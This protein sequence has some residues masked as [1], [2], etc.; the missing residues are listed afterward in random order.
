MD[1]SQS[2]DGAMAW[3]DAILVFVRMSQD[4]SGV[5]FFRNWHVEADVSWFHDVARSRIQL[6]CCSNQVLLDP[7]KWHAVST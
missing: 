4:K 2:L 5:L 1:A 6:D 3:E 7:N